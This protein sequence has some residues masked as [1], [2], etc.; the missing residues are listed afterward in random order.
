MLASTLIADPVANLQPNN[1]RTISNNGAALP[2]PV[3]MLLVPP[4]P[5]IPRI[6]D[7]EPTVI[8]AG[9][10]TGAAVDTAV[11]RP[12]RRRRRLGHIIGT[13]PRRHLRLP[14]Q[15]VAHIIVQR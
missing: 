3:P 6:P 10:A 11:A 4:P 15:P 9:T 2:T 12:R 14:R 13:L 5:S 1:S 8:T 7:P